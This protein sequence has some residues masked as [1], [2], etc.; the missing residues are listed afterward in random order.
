MVFRNIASVK[1]Q[2]YPLKRI[3]LLLMLKISVEIAC[4]LS[5]I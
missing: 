5:D 1:I 2:I 4:F 3:K